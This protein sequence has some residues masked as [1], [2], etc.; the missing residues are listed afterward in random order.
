MELQV[1][2]DVLSSVVS[3]RG[4]MWDKIESF[5]KYLNTLKGTVNHKAGTEQSEILKDTCPIKQHI[6]GGLYTREIFMPKGSLI[7]SMIHKQNHPSFLLKGDPAK[8]L[9]SKKK[10]V[11]QVKAVKSTVF[12]ILFEGCQSN[13]QTTQPNTT[14]QGFP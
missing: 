10:P 8:Y 7:V 14:L 11:P 13:P 1:A 3:R 12:W 9:Y 4:I 5:Q 2:H 6:D